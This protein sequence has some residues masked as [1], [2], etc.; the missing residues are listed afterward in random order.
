MSTIIVISLFLGLILTYI[1]LWVL[2]LRI[3]LRWVK[4]NKITMRRVAYATILV[5]YLFIGR[6]AGGERFDDCPMTTRP[7]TLLV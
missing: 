7:A 4:V 3:G 6:L 5:F 1:L 2:F